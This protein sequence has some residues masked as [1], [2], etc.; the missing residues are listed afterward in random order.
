MVAVTG[1][2]T[3]TGTITPGTYRAGEIIECLTER[4]MEEQL[5]DRVVL[6]LGPTQHNTFQ[7]TTY[8]DMNGSSISY[9]PPTVLQ[10][11]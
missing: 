4:V 7:N 6:I 1:N 8:I 3:T 5:L 11:M 9:T 10:I 2:L